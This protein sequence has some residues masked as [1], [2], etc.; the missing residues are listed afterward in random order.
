M[1]GDRYGFQIGKKEGDSAI[2][3]DELEEPFASVP[4]ECKEGESTA[5]K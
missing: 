2:R 3:G 4:L 5:E 1:A